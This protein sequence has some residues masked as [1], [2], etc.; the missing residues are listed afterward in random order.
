MRPAKTQI[1]LHIS[2]F[3]QSSQGSL[4]VAKFPKRLQ[5]DRETSDQ[6]GLSVVAGLV[7]GNA[8]AQL[9]I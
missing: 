2:Q 7:V 9:K 1:S 8:E 6:T 4:W 3:D 5:P